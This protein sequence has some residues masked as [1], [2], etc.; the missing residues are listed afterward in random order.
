MSNHLSRQPEPTRR[1][2]AQVNAI[3][4]QMI[5]GARHSTHCCIARH[6]FKSSLHARTEVARARRLPTKTS[7]QTQHPTGLPPPCAREHPSVV[8]S[9][10]AAPGGAF[11]VS[12]TTGQG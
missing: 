5:R 10:V 12:G 3:R 1:K 2:P 9:F 6:A 4:N 11:A 8:S 7:S